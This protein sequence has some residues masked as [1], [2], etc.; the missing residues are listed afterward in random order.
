MKKKINHNK[1]HKSRVCK[2]TSK[3]INMGDQVQGYAVL[4]SQQA[5]VRSES[6]W[7]GGYFIIWVVV[8]II[9]LAILAALFSGAGDWFSNDSSSSDDRHHGK[10]DSFNLSA[11]GGLV[12]FIIVLLFLA[13]LINSVGCGGSDRRF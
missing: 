2:F 10:R 13:W 4:P 11:L 3:T 1:I 5:A 6:H 8:F 9:F 7:G 12:V